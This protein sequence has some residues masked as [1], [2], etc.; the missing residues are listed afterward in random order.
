[1]SVLAISP[2][3]G[4]QRLMTVAQQ[5]IVRPSL[6]ELCRPDA[7]YVPDPIVEIAAGLLEMRRAG[8]LTRLYVD[9]SRTGASIIR[10]ATGQDLT[11][12]S[13]HD[14]VAIVEWFRTTRAERRARVF[15]RGG[16]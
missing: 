14:A 5:A 15:A 10:I 12:I 9:R 11:R 16:K 2:R 1:M 6:G 3:D 7:P 8:L 13:Y 4:L